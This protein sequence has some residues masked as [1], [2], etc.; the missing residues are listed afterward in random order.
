M[1]GRRWVSDDRPR[2]LAGKADRGAD[3]GDSARRENDGAR[4]RHT[5]HLRGGR[6]VHRTGSRRGTGSNGSRLDAPARLRHQGAVADGTKPG[7]TYANRSEISPITAISSTLCLMVKR[8]SRASSADVMPVAATA[9][10]MLW[11]E[12]ILPITPAAEFTDVVRIG[13]RP[14][15][16]A[17]TA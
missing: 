2:G 14:S 9:T 5:S 13:L 15:V 11:T 1:R 12:I 7:S 6:E 4:S 10:A 8:N 17:V 3:A 16:L